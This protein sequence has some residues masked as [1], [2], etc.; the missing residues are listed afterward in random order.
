MKRVLIILPF[1]LPFLVHQIYQPINENWTVRR[2]GCGCPPVLGPGVREW[3]FNANEFNS[4]VWVAVASTCVLSW[5]LLV[6]SA[7]TNRRTTKYFLLQMSG[8]YV[9]VFICM[10]QLALE[11]W[12]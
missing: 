11:F 1:A 4:I 8:V 9:L 6:R 2:F 12:L 7:F 5:W 3:N 10:R